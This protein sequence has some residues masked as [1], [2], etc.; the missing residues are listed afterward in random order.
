MSQRSLKPNPVFSKIFPHCAPRQEDSSR[1]PPVTDVEGTDFIFLLVSISIKQLEKQVE[2]FPSS[3]EPL[4]YETAIKIHTEHHFYQGV[5]NSAKTNLHSGKN[6]HA[7]RS[8]RG[9]HLKHQGPRKK[10]WGGHEKVCHHMTTDWLHDLIECL[11]IEE[12]IHTEY[13]RYMYMI[14]WGE[15]IVVQEP[16]AS[17]V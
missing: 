1:C 9:R 13:L 8:E 12:M 10:L 16:F 14:K 5:K 11:N 15:R 2:L 7:I 4:M 6:W 17:Q 3:L